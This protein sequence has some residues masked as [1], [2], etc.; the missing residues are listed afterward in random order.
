M[1]ELFLQSTLNLHRRTGAI[2]GQYHCRFQADQGTAPPPGA[3]GPSNKLSIT[4]CQLTLIRFM[5]STIFFLAFVGLFVVEGMIVFLHLLDFRSR[6]PSVENP[7]NK[8]Y[9][10]GLS[11]RVTKRDLEKHFSA[12]GKVEDIHLVGDP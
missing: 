5:L 7:G 11:A 3:R 10:T 6:S 1:M 12:E 2:S 8:L 9:V 4:V